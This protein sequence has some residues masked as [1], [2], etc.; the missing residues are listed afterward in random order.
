MTRMQ[1]TPKHQLAVQPAGN[2]T[3]DPSAAEGGEGATG[4]G[5]RLMIIRIR[6]ILDDPK[7]LLRDD[8]EAVYRDCIDL[9][10]RMNTAEVRT[11]MNS[12]IK[13]LESQSVSPDIEKALSDSKRR[14]RERYHQIGM[15]LGFGSV[16]G[17]TESRIREIVRL[18]DEQYRDTVA[19]LDAVSRE[20]QE[21]K[22]TLPSET[23]Q[24][25][26]CTCNPK[27]DRINPSCEAHGWDW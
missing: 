11:E 17:I 13:S 3:P 25:L 4:A 2:E 8:E 24:P 19:A 14:L 12:A 1:Q 27:G 23:A 7:R 5:V 22:G 21:T 9:L 15:Q 16:D 26:K 18:C 6:A 10:E 20:L